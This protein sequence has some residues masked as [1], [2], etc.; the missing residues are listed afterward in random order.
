MIIFL[1]HIK[2][3]CLSSVLIEVLI[4]VWQLIHFPPNLLNQWFG[5][6]IVSSSS[7]FLLSFDLILIAYFEPLIFERTLFGSNG[8]YWFVGFHRLAQIIENWFLISKLMA[9]KSVQFVPERCY[10]QNQS[11]FIRHNMLGMPT[12][13][14]VFIFPLLC[15]Y[16]GI[17]FSRLHCFCLFLAMFDF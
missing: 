1:F 6:I 15:V 4:P 16:S 3:K 11:P 12:F 9:K 13:G 7:F 17:R 14:S 2:M 10:R 5:F 8:R